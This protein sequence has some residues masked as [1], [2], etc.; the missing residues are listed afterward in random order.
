ML[1]EKGVVILSQLLLV[2]VLVGAWG[3]VRYGL[4]VML[5]AIPQFLAISDLGLSI[6]AGVR[7]TEAVAAEDSARQRLIYHT[8]LATITSVCA[9]VAAVGLGVLVALSDVLTGVAGVL[10]AD[11][12]ITALVLLLFY[13]CG[14]LAGGTLLVPLKAYGHLHLSVSW[15]ATTLACEAVAT[16]VV[17]TIGG[18]LVEAAAALLAVRITAL[19]LLLVLTRSRVPRGTMGW[20]QASRQEF[21]AQLGPGLSAMA[22]PV[23]QVTMLHGTVLAVGW[24]AGPAAAAVVAVVR[25]LSRIGLQLAT[26]V[27]RAVWYDYSAA[28]QSGMEARARRLLWLGLG[29]T[30]ALCIPYTIGLLLFGEPAVALWTGGEIRP[31]YAVIA[32]MA[33]GTVFAGLWNIGIQ[34]LAALNQ[35]RAASAIL[36]VVA[37]MQVALAAVLSKALGCLGWRHHAGGGRC[38]DGRCLPD[39]RTHAAG[40]L[41]RRAH[42]A[43]RSLW[44]RPPSRARCTVIETIVI[45]VL[46]LGI[47]LLLR[48]KLF[49]ALGITIAFFMVGAVI[50]YIMYRLGNFVPDN[51]LLPFERLPIDRAFL[52][53]CLGA[54]ATGIAYFL[55]RRPMHDTQAPTYRDN[56]ASLMV[57]L[58]FAA[59]VGAAIYFALVIFVSGSFSEALLVSQGRARVENSIYNLAEIFSFVAQ[60]CPV[61]AWFLLL[62][63]DDRTPSEIALVG[64]AVVLGAGLA[65]ASGGRSIMVLFLLALAWGRL[66]RLNLVGTAVAGA[67][68]ALAIGILSAVFIGLRYDAQGFT[69]ARGQSTLELATTGLTFVDHI[70][71]AIDYSDWNG[72]TYGQSYLN[73]FALVIPRDFWPDKPLQLSILMREFYYGDTLGGAPPG[74]YGEALISGGIVGIVL[75]GIAFGLAVAKLDNINVRAGNAGSPID[76]AFAGLFVPMVPYALIRGGFDIGFI[77]VGIP[78]ALS[79]AIVFI[80]NRL[81]DPLRSKLTN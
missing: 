76:I 4:W 51:A 15:Q 19:L 65:F 54:S 38:G 11:G 50:P 2:P 64:A 73:A 36:I 29:L 48:I 59:F 21:R 35:L 30:V 81:A 41:Y 67:I 58:C 71:L 26:I 17:A 44:C 6:A 55:G 28:A 40:R 53:F 24:A 57:A 27:V 33:A 25:T 47:V 5:I 10:S 20:R 49:S 70:A 63:R 18:G 32:V 60:V 45:C 62:D 31:A 12:L 22:M 56:G 14:V 72:L 34:Y 37:V 75:I 69:G 3:D 1:Y 43:G 80:A 9:V 39:A 42:V 78:L 79:I 61:F 74:L 8:A 23:G 7:L 77:R 68:G 13:G 52:L 66:I 46:A 16:G